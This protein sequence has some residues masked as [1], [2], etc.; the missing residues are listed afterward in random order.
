MK[1]PNGERKTVYGLDKVHDLIYPAQLQGANQFGATL[2][3]T[4]Q[5][6]T[7]EDEVFKT[8][9]DV[10]QEK[11]VSFRFI[12]EQLDA[13]TFRANEMRTVHPPGPGAAVVQF[14]G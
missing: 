7:A 5:Y 6:P 2:T 1:L 12:E 13:L 11:K 10:Q 4:S 14:R 3:I 8:W 9:L